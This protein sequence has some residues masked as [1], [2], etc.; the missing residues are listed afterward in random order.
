MLDVNFGDINARAAARLGSRNQTGRDVAKI[1]EIN[2][3]K[4]YM[5]CNLLVVLV[6]HEL[7]S[8][9]VSLKA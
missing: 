8:T 5:Y 7:E 2:A 9:F 4:V 1:A 6:F 3:Y